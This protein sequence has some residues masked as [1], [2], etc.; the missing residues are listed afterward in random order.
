MIRRIAALAVLALVPLAA[1][2]DGGDDDPLTQAEF[3]D[4][5]TEGDAVDDETAECV[6]GSVYGAL[7]DDELDKLTADA[8][9]GEEAPSPA[10][11]EALTTA[12]GDCLTG[13]ADDA[14]GTVEEGAAL[15]VPQEI[16]D[17]YAA[18]EQ[19]GDETQLFVIQ[20]WAEEVGRTEI[21]EAI[22]FLTSDPPTETAEEQ[23]AY[24]G[25]VDFVR[26]ELSGGG[27]AFA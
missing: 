3:A 2:G 13:G 24:E 1:C 26:G 12:I 9:D 20:G 27:C 15:E 19:D 25:A 22:D 23:S 21:S 14:A 17:S 5:L 10:I 11:E 16:C 18:W 7:D 8:L 4:A 6:A